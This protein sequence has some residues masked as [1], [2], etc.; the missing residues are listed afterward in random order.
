MPKREDETRQS[1]FGKHPVYCTCT[2]CT[3]RFLQ[4]KGIKPGKV[5][6]KPFGKTGG[7]K[8]MAH[9]ADCTCAT[10]SL[11]RSVDNLLPVEKRKAGL[12]Q[13]LLGRK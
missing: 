1:L 9:P 11:L 10:C 7:E 5:A 13:R 2:Q 4:K 8:V 3:E 6:K 12:L